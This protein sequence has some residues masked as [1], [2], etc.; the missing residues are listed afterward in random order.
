L[1]KG[2]AS[3]KGDA[4]APAPDTDPGAISSFV[5]LLVPSFRKGG[6]GWILSIVIPESLNRESSSF[7]SLR[8][9]RTIVSAARQS[10]EKNEILN[11]VQDDEKMSSS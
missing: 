2:E 4:T 10:H 7:L 3:A 9:E 8:A 5:F 1:A 11:R 6:L